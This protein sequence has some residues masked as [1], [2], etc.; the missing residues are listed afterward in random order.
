M[1]FR[2]IAILAASSL[3]WAQAPSGEPEH[4]QDVQTVA[5]QRI[6]AGMHFTEGPVWSLDDFLVFNDTVENTRNVWAPGK[7]VLDTVMLAGGGSGNAFDTDENFY[8]CEF[9]ERRVVRIDKKGKTTVVADRFEGKRLNAPNDVVVRKDG[10]IYFTDPAFGNQL[11]SQELDFY[12]VYRVDKKGNLEAIARWQTRPNGIALS[13][14]G[15]LLFVSDADAQTVHAF[16]LD[17]DGAASND[18]VAVSGIPGAPG[19]LATDEDGNIYVAADAV[20]VYSPEG[21]LIRTIRMNEKASNVTFGDPDFRALYV[22]ARGS[23][24]R[25]RLGVRGTVP[26]FD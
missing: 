14:D 15:K 18:R 1:S 6:V 23:V 24:Y 2:P 13:F 5:V 7:G 22:T 9:R 11:D 8:I 17:R 3:C 10:N 19:G 25:I 26:H 16:D 20:E 4:I 21:E 12:G